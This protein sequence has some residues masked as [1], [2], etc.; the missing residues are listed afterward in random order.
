M[1]FDIIKQKGANTADNA[2]HTFHNLS[3]LATANSMVV[4]NILLFITGNFV[5]TAFVG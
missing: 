3:P 1:V 2:M 4:R 5:V